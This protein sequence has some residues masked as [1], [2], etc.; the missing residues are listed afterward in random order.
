MSLPLDTPIS[1]LPKTHS[2]TISRLKLIG[3]ETL[4]DLISYLPRR[5]IDYSVVSKISS[6]QP[7]ETLTIKGK[8]TKAQNRFVRR[9]LSI[10]EIVISDGTGEIT[11]FWYNQP[12]LVK[13]FQKE[14]NGL[15]C[16]GTIEKRGKKLIIKPE[17]YEVIVDIESSDT[18][19]TGKI[20]P[21]YPEKLHLSSRTLRDKITTALEMTD[22]KSMPE[23]MPV[24]I[25]TKHNLPPI[26]ESLIQV[27]LPNSLKSA[28]TARRR[29]AL[30]ELFLLH[31][32]RQLVR[33]SWHEKKLTKPFE[34]N[35]KAK[36]LVE[37][38]LG[39]LPF[40]LTNSQLKAIDEIK[41]DLIKNVPMNRFVQGDV[42]SGKTVIAA[43]SSLVPIAN[44]KKVL[45]MAPTSILANQ[46]F[47][48]LSRIFEGSEIKVGLVTGQ[49]SKKPRNSPAPRSSQSEV[50]EVEAYKSN[51]R[52][53]HKTKSN[54]ILQVTDY[55][56]VVGTHAL[57]TDDRAFDN[58]G[59]IVI[60]EQHRFGVAQRAILKS[61]AEV[62][63]LLTMTATPIPRTLALS[64]FGDLDLSVLTDM[65]PGRIPI[66]TY[67]APP[68]KRKG[69]Y[70]WIR[71]QIKETGCQAFVICPRIE[72]DEEEGNKESKETLKNVTDE[73]EK[74]QKEIYPELKIAML[75]GKMKPKE[76]DEVM[77]KFKNKEFH[78]LISTTVVEVGIDI[79]NATIIL[80]EGSERYGLAQLHQ[81]RG[82]V[83]RNS[84]QSYCLL[85]TSDNFPIT[86][87]LKF[88]AKTTNGMDLAEYDFRHRGP[89][90]MFGT[91]QHG[92]DGLK[93]ASLFDFAL[94]NESQ[95]MASEFF[96][97]YTA[98]KFPEIA[99][100]LERFSVDKVAKD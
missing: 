62:P 86:E 2:S 24:E 29:F 45:I 22:P 9:N 69:A 50:G 98:S 31:L 5:Y 75:H 25:V 40:K 18:R 59:L 14:N 26:G 15:A 46:H 58:V 30:E 13:Q 83:G 74:L 48:T 66:K 61:K 32:S 60:D 47:S 67:A 88:F 93:V 21:I 36:K 94:V 42:G 81:L 51:T 97:K 10:Q 23:W 57:L 56:I 6:A 52:S 80:I 3:I 89:G 27:H 84:V 12:Y 33:K 64:I 41:N 4:G 53:K 92:L 65:P 90:D 72:N 39:K 95:S 54:D 44:G 37:D 96:P 16:A 35:E 99:K 87:R 91:A 78:I 17:E 38:L 7:G 20:V 34:Y 49:T 77:E 85:F 8:V 79:P 71:K 76:K 11:A 19:H 73:L 55:N 43:I 63:H 28:E 82:R 1:I 100:R 68:E 70:E